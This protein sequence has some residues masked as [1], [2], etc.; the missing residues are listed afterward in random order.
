MSLET[1]NSERAKN[2]IEAEE[3]RSTAAPADQPS[4]VTTGV[5]DGLSIDT[6]EQDHFAT[7]HLLTGLKER[8]VSS[9]VVTMVAQGAQFV[10]TLA[11]TMVLAR[12]LTPQDF[13]L[14][15]MVTTVIGF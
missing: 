9:G 10:L 15:A 11:S 4:Q 12:L 14:V 8:A 7:D 6:A 3:T 13:G 1:D 2:M 5:F